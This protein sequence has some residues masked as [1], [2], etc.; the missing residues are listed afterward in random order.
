MFPFAAS[1]K[2]K[3]FCEYLKKIKILWTCTPTLL[4]FS[5][6]ILI[7]GNFR[8]IDGEKIRPRVRRPPQWVQGKAPQ[9]ILD[10]VNF[11]LLLRGFPSFKMVSFC[12]NLH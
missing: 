5:I 10:L 7:G 11:D 6:H 3:S 4:V 12:L 8:I 2:K 1:T 9:P